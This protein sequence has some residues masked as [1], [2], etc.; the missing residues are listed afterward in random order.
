MLET[1]K[2]LSFMGVLSSLFILLT[3][4]F[5]VLITGTGAA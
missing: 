3:L 5:G 1:K 4:I 2:K